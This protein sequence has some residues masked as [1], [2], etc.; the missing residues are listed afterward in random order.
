M[1]RDPKK[2]R[3]PLQIVTL[4]Y[5]AVI[6]T[7][8]HLPPRHLPHV[9]VRDKIEHLL[10]YGCLGGLLF[11]TL[12]LT[13]PKLAHLGILVLA[14]GMTYGALDEWTQPFFG[15]DCEFMD[16]TADTSGLA[17]AVVCLTFLRNRASNF[18]PQ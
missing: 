18:T 16:W 10:A 7:L 1:I 2:L 17:I 12:W 13:R 15:R 5:W 3:L 8:T 6:L 9:N 14:V 4:I 11:L